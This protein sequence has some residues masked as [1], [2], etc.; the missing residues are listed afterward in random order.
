MPTS[1][2]AHATARRGRG[3]RDNLALAAV[4]FAV[5]TLAAEF[6]VRA[7]LHEELD[8]DLL[9]ARL[10]GTSIRSITRPSSDPDIFF[11]LKPDRLIHFRGA[12]VRIHRRGYRTAAGADGREKPPAGAVRILALGDST[13]FGWGVAYEE[14]YPE[15]YR[16]EMERLAGRAVVLENHS[17]PGYNTR[18][19]LGALRRVLRRA[20]PHLILLHYDHNDPEP[21]NQFNNL[22]AMGF[23]PPDY[24]DNIFHSA[25]I[26]LTARQIRTSALRD[27]F[28]YR[29][30]EMFDG[31]LHGGP[32]YEAHL[33]SL[34]EIVRRAGDVP[35][36]AVIFDAHT[37]RDESAP[38]RHYSRLHE[39]LAEHLETA[40]FHLLDLYPHLQGEMQRQGWEDLSAWHL[41]EDDAHPGAA[42]HAFVAATLASHTRQRPE[43]ARLFQ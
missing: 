16:R 24:G 32:D 4:S 39:G 20:A 38:S 40:G 10:E 22:L 15:L 19:E 28:G 2:T 5:A 43:L 3:L 6:V 36:V 8:T 34:R 12:W 29:G 31:Y 41:S 27:R 30:G 9:R 7:V 26:K 33:E 18:Q 21:P 14:S 42:G 1:D 35:V 17:V 11:E 23:L 25:L 37:R 13:S